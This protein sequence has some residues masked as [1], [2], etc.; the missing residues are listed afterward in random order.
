MSKV[1]ISVNSNF[2]KVSAIDG[3]A[4]TTLK[5]SEIVVMPIGNPIAVV[6]RIPIN[7]AP[8]TFFASNTPVIINPIRASNGTPAV[9]SP[10]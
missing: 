9:I 6:T 3:G 7:N 1:K 4:E 2:I 8:F 10:S 5:P